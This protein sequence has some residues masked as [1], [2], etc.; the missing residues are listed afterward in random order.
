MFEVYCR[1][2]SPSDVARL[3]LWMWEHICLRFPL[4]RHMREWRSFVVGGIRSL[5]AAEEDIALT[6]PFPRHLFAIIARARAVGIHRFLAVLFI[7]RL[8]TIGF[9]IFPL[10]VGIIGNPKLN[11]QHTQHL[12]IRYPACSIDV[13]V[14][15]VD[16]AIGAVRMRDDPGEVVVHPFLVDG[17]GDGIR[18]SVGWGCC[19]LAHVG[20]Y[21]YSRQC[22]CVC[23]CTWGFKW[24]IIGSLR[25]F[26]GT[27]RLTHVGRSIHR[28]VSSKVTNGDTGGQ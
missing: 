28:F 8:S 7:H 4:F 14:H 9:F 1:H 26:E 20:G 5:R 25:K 19:G 13:G 12:R 24:S 15:R 6:S 3:A 18:A 23:A 2:L 21:T 11:T 17:F 10:L 16:S 27:H 22:V